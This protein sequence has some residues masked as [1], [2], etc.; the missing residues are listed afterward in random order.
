MKKQHAFECYK[1]RFGM[2][3]EGTPN[4][5]ADIEGID[6]KLIPDFDLLTGGFPCQDYSSANWGSKGIV[7]KKGVLWWSIIDI[8][9]TK[10]PKFALFENVNAL[11]ISPKTKTEKGRDF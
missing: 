5:N 4:P 7:G 10:K 6:K 9:R 8:L 11:L 3:A 1:A 2:P